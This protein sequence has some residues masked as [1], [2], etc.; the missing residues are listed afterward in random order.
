MVARCRVEIYQNLS[1]NL[2]VAEKYCGMEQVAGRGLTR[3]ATERSEAGN[4]G[5]DPL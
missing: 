4:S 1:Q 2:T 3:C 5:S